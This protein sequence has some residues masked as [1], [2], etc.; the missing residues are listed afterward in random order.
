MKFSVK[1]NKKSILKEI[2]E[3]KEILPDIR[4]YNIKHYFP[5]KD[6]TNI[7]EQ[8]IKDEK[9][10]NPLDKKKKVNL[11]ITKNKEEI[12]KV[13]SSIGFKVSKNKK[14]IIFLN[15]YGPEGYF[16]VPNI[17]IANIHNKKI[18]FITETIIHELIHLLIEK[19]YKNKSYQE[20]EIL[21]DNILVTNFKKIIPN[22]KPQPF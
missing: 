1:Y 11:W 6:N 22:Y 9:R 21:V 7:K 16:Y 5:F 8:I 4:K 17:I 3:I 14:F 19:K 15:L 2:S 12:E 10:D 18:D 20:K 13:I